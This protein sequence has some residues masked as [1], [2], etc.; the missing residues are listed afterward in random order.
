MVNNHEDC[1]VVNLRK[2]TPL[3]LWEVFSDAGWGEGFF[4]LTEPS[5]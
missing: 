5:P 3:S 2:S 4:I 1:K